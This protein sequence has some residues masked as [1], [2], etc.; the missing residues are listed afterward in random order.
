MLV[1]LPF[2]ISGKRYAIKPLFIPIWAGM[3]LLQYADID[4]L[5]HLWWW[6]CAWVAV[7]VFAFWFSTEQVQDVGESPHEP[8]NDRSGH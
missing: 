8:K 3:G 6:G 5:D 2:K 1:N 7:F 4:T